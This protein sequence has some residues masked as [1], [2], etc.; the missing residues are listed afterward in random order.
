MVID[1]HCHAGKGDL[2]TAPWNTD[3]PIEPY[4]RRAGA[5]GIAKTVVFAPFHSDYERAN[6]EVARIVARYPS[7]LIG[8]AFVHALRDRGR[9]YRMVARAV[10]QWKFR[11]I[12]IHGHEAMPNRE[13]CETARSLNLPLLV[14][15]AGQ[16]HVID[17]MAPQ[18]PE[19]SFIVP[20]LGSFGDDWRA[21]QHVVDQLV[22]YPNVYSDTSGVRRFD[23]IVQAV[24]RAGPRKLLFGSDGPWLHPGV[25][26]HKI[27][28]LGLP[29]EKEAL[30]LGE[31]A[32]RLLKM[33][34]PAF[35]PPAEPPAVPILR[36]AYSQ[37][38][39]LVTEHEL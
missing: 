4:L 35:R 12:K 27:R 22:R 21:H 33:D 8:F 13:V 30:I 37:P 18:Y 28:L 14:D 34:R 10:K 9:I 31:N 16:T 38:S 3:A 15:V 11:G 32:M 26:L 24:K 25:E 17:M 2:M 6:A 19:V 29:K 1:A 7:R 39:E 5:A 20:H 23:Y 36:P